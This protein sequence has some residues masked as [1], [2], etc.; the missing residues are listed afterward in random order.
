MPDKTPLAGKINIF[1][2]QTY[3]VIQRSGATGDIIITGIFNQ[4]GSHDVEASFNGG[5]YATI[6][7]GVASGAEF[8]GTLTGQAEG[9]GTLTVRLVDTP[10]VAATVDYVGI[11]DIFVIAGQSNAMGYGTNNQVYAGALA[12]AVFGNDYDWRDCVDPVDRNTLQKDAV[13]DD[14]AVPAGSVWPLLATLIMADQSV[15]VAFVPCAKG[16]TGITAWQP[17]ADHQDRTTLYGSMAYRALQTGCKAVLYWG[18][19]TDAA[20]AMNQA[21]F[22]AYLDAFAN[23]VQ[24]DLGVTVMPCQMQNCAG[25]ADVQEAAIRAACVEA[26]GDNANVE[27]GPDLSGLASDDNY[28]LMTDAKL[29]AAADLWWAALDAALYT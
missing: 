23:A 9:Q 29:S 28:H 24:A 25:I 1:T 15:P 16:A 12:A 17:G 7:S 19:V 11:G 6:A 5:A 26:W 20:A 14:G 10:A 13:S 27:A 8:S 2:P 18:Y 21:T 4:A 22:N 3:Q